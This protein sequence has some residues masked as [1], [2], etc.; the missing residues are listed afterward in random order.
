[1]GALYNIPLPL[2]GKRNTARGYLQLFKLCSISFCAPRGGVFTVWVVK[3]YHKIVKPLE[4]GKGFF[5]FVSCAMPIISEGDV[6]GC[7]ASLCEKDGARGK[8]TLGGELEAKLI[9]TAAGFLG[10]QLEG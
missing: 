5:H 1:M 10:R 6:V 9:Q 7:V 3:L 2:P 8:E 4:G